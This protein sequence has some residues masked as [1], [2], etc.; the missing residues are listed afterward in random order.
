[1]SNISL[2]RAEDWNC[3]L[4]G[5]E[6]SSTGHQLSW[7]E[8]VASALQG[9]MD[10]E[11]LIK[12]CVPYLIAR[13]TS[14][15]PAITIA[16]LTAIIENGAAD[17][18]AACKAAAGSMVA[19]AARD[20][21]AFIFPRGDEMLKKAAADA[22]V[23]TDDLYLALQALAPLGALLYGDDSLVVLPSR[24]AGQFELV[25]TSDNPLKCIELQKVV[26]MAAK[27]KFCRVQLSR[28]ADQSAQIYCHG[29]IFNADMI[30]IFAS[31]INEERSRITMLFEGA[32]PDISND[33]MITAGVTMLRAVFGDI[34]GRIILQCSEIHVYRE[35]TEEIQAMVDEAS[36]RNVELNGQELRPVNLREF[37]KNCMKSSMR[38]LSKENDLMYIASEIE[39]RNNWTGPEGSTALRDDIFE[40]STQR[41]F[42]PDSRKG[43]LT[44]KYLRG[45]VASGAL[46]VS[47]A[48]SIRNDKDNV[49]TLRRSENTQ[50]IRDLER[51]LRRAQCDEWLYITGNA[52]GHSH[53]YV[54]V[55]VFDE[56]RLHNALKDWRASTRLNVDSIELIS[57][58]A[59]AAPFDL[60]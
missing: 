46:P 17:A 3:S 36:R 52:S 59:G 42:S 13:C 44:S 25:F 33:E 53:A 11:E 60:V 2:F 16:P 29:Q 26:N 22:G 21:E 23:S 7:C 28:K 27:I 34:H 20:L 55:I 45:I 56:Q 19:D 43:E 40:Y 37:Y 8:Y 47:I 5:V 24:V 10:N 49:V 54:D 38:K 58:C 1:M 41:S 6:L 48:V 51:A 14:L 12:K 32:S 50:I 4:S 15:M 9:I 57:P 30:R 39:T 18:A 31:A 35:I